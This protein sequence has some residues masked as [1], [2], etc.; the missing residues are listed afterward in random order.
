MSI[1]PSA[2]TESWRVCS[3]GQLPTHYLIH[4][5]LIHLTT[6]AP[7]AIFRFF[8]DL[9]PARRE[10]IHIFNLRA[11]HPGQEVAAQ[12]ASQGSRGCVRPQTMTLVKPQKPQSLVTFKPYT[13]HCTSSSTLAHVSCSSIY[14]IIPNRIMYKN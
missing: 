14:S 4:F 5:H 6:V 10:H 11:T 7:L 13:V 1:Y 12:V 9:T 8:G 2:R 3:T